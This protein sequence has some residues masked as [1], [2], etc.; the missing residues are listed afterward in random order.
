MKRT[1][2]EQLPLPARKRIEGTT[3]KRTYFEFTTTKTALA[4]VLD[5]KYQVT[6]AGISAGENLDGCVSQI[7]GTRNGIPTMSFMRDTLT[8]TAIMLHR[9]LTGVGGSYAT[10]YQDAQP[11]T[12]TETY[13]YWILHGPFAPGK[14]KF[15]VE[16]RP[17]TDEFGGAT[18]FS[19]DIGIRPI[20]GETKHPPITVRARKLY[21]TTDFTT[22]R[23]HLWGISGT[24]ANI[25]S[26]T[27][28]DKYKLSADQVEDLK[29]LW[30][31]SYPNGTFT[32][33][34]TARL[35][36][37]LRTPKRMRGLLTTATTLT[38]VDAVFYPK[39]R[40]RPTPVS[41]PTKQHLYEV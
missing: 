34:D 2:Y 33:S 11:T 8:D 9:T 6:D 36:T 4:F 22:S 12:E 7:V 37:V 20:L 21:L 19:A 28:D 18:A 24:I 17:I 3:P 16:L 30:Y 5:A 41:P 13:A 29:R 26:Y 1:A 39:P 38:V 15:L 40:P 10:V 23:C 27:Y 32:A 31:A 25:D 14:Y 35:A